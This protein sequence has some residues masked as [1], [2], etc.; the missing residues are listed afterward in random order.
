MSYVVHLGT[1]IYHKCIT[2]LDTLYI[3]R[4]EVLGRGFSLGSG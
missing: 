1:M 2:K 3:S 4:P